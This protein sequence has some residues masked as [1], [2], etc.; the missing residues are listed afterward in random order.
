MKKFI[1]ATFLIAA[2]LIFIPAQEAKAAYNVLE[3]G[4]QAQLLR[5][6]YNVPAAEADFNSKYNDYVYKTQHGASQADIIAAQTAMNAA[7]VKLTQLN[8]LI[9]YQ[10]QQSA[11]F[12]VPATYMSTL[13]NEPIYA[14][15]YADKSIYATA[16]NNM[17]INNSAKVNQGAYNAVLATNGAY[18]VDMANVTAYHAF[19][20]GQAPYPW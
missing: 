2:C 6:M 18:A 9:T 7:S 13:M 11:A 14:A 8:A 1:T 20:N 15:V 19:Y 3:A 5:S 17:A 4:A 12:P 10:M 16:L